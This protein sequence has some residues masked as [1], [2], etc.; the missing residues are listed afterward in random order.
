[1]TRNDKIL[2]ICGWIAWAT[3]MFVAIKYL[4]LNIRHI[5]DLRL[6]LAFGFL[7][8]LCVNQW[9]WFR[10]DSELISQMMVVVYIQFY[11]VL[12]FVTLRA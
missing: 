9:R 5:G 6:F 2:R 11:F 7:T 12:W 4:A 10:S 3:S 1:M 8:M